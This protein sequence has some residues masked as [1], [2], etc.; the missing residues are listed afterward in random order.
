MQDGTQDYR[1]KQ[2]GDKDISSLNMIAEACGSVKPSGY[3]ETSLKQR[4]SLLLKR[5]AA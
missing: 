5:P 4:E 3:F 2:A 1:I